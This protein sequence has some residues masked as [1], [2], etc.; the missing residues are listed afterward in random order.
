MAKSDSSME[1]RDL[2]GIVGSR[3]FYNVLQRRKVF[4]QQQVNTF[5]RD[6]DLINAYAAL[7]KYDDIDKMVDIF[8]KRIKELEKEANDG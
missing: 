7:A 6:Q 2:K 5:I 8:K 1:V 4:M 3:A